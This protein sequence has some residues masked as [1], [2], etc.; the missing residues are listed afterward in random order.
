ME[1]FLLIDAAAEYGMYSSDITR[2][3]PINGKY[4][5]EQK[6]VYSEVLKAQNL[7]IDMV[8]TQNTMQDVHRGNNCLYF[9]VP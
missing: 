6:A 2:T 5:P 9:R 1:N 3:F 8:T 7:G 4:T